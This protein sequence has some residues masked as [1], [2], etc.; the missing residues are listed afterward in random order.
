MEK[1]TF[2]ELAKRILKEE[3]KPLSATDIWEIAKKKGYD[4]LLHSQGKTPWA[5]LGAQLYCNVREKDSP[6]VKIGTRPKLFYLRK[7][8]S[9]NEL[10]LI[11]QTQDEMVILPKQTEYLEKD[12]H[13]FLAYYAN[14]YLKAY[15]KTIQ[16]SKSDKKEFGEWIHPDMVGCYFPI[17]DWKPE[18][19]EFGAA[20]G[21]M[22]I[23]IFSFEIKKELTFGNLR[24]SFFQTVSNSSWAHEGYLVAAEISVDEDF[25]TELRRLSTSFGVGVIKINIDDTDSSE[26]LFPAKTRENLDWDTINKLTMN[27]DFKDFLK[28]IKT[29]ISS[30][31]IR[32]EKYDKVCSKEELVKLIK[33]SR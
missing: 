13:P 4:M 18:V 2:I 26:I 10:Q 15:T 28:R 17:E 1:L 19:V 12:L 3:K 16:H 6:F 21:G 33:K 25:Q 9:N 31:E 32:K 8:I 20:I 22:A 27:T 30:K 7:L 14:Y 23:K 29:D 5:T 11:E 24:E